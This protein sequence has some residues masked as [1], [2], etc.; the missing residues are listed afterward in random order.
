[1]SPISEK[2]AGFW[3]AFLAEDESAMVALVRLEP[4][5]YSSWADELMSSAMVLATG[6]LAQMKPAWAGNQKLSAL[7][8]TELALKIYEVVEDSGRPVIERGI[9]AARRVLGALRDSAPDD[10][11]NL[12]ILR[13]EE[14]VA[15]RKRLEVY[16][17]S[18]HLTDETVTQGAELVD[19]Q[20]RASA[21]SEAGDKAR[22]QGDTR[23]AEEGYSNAID[24]LERMIG[25]S[26]DR[27]T[28]YSSLSLVHLKM[29]RVALYERN[30]PKMEH[31]LLEA[32]RNAQLA[33]K[34]EPDN[35]AYWRSLSTVEGG[36]AARAAVTG[37]PERCREHLEARLDANARLARL[38]PD[39]LQTVAATAATHE[40]LGELALRQ[41]RFAEV[42]RH[43]LQAVEAY[44]RLVVAVPGQAGYERGRY[45]SY[46]TLGTAEVQ[47]GR[48]I[49]GINHLAMASTLAQEQLEIRGDMET[50]ILFSLVEYERALASVES[51]DP[52]LALPNLEKACK[53]SDGIVD[54]RLEELRSLCAIKQN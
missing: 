21:Y 33:V 22:A 38:E 40:Q 6:P 48:R 35:P 41:Q 5:K 29:S 52:R 25:S 17:S 28:V 12:R 15:L 23:K 46:A 7:D 20:E 50:R 13:L 37:D 4:E 43:A 39:D 1:M 3:R 51:G 2:R 16:G 27:A 8:L 45:M 10:G 11:Q 19:L 47:S 49:S 42:I 32:A 34:L 26:I 14:A 54:P 9:L 31:H 18:G 36:L 30:V 24:I 44:E 53:L